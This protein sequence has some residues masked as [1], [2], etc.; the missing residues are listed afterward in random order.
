MIP[1]LASA[2]AAET[3][4]PP[5]V[6][7]LRKT[8]SLFGDFALGDGSRHRCVPAGKSLGDDHDVRNDVEVVDPEPAPGPTKAADH[9]VCNEQGTVAVADLADPGEVAGRRDDAAGCRH[10]RF[11]D[12]AGRQFRIGPE[13]RLLDRRAARQLAAWMRQPQLAAVAVGRHRIRETGSG[14]K[15]VGAATEDAEAGAPTRRRQGA[16]G[17]AMVGAPQRDDLVATA[18]A[19]RLVILASELDRSFHRLRAAVA[20]EGIGHQVA[21]SQLGELACQLDRATALVVPYGLVYC[22]RWAC[23]Y[24]ARA[25]SSRPYPAS[26]AKTP[27][28][29]ASMYCG[30][31]RRRGSLPP[32]GRAPRGRP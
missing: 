9:L 30:R 4:C 18:L 29:S 7:T 5:Y 16:D 13:D 19:V 3:G 20:E 11:E 28:E 27:P 21:G 10:D 17:R 25:I 12:D 32:R 31:P 15:W 23:S 1:I 26:T 14:D 6:W 2:A 8:G 24:I 22:S